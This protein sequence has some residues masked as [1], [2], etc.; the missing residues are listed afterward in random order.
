LKVLIVFFISL[1]FIGCSLTNQTNVTYEK[2]KP[3]KEVKNLPSNKVLKVLN[4]PINGVIKGNVVNI[5]YIDNAWIYYV[6]GTD[7][8]NKK[9]SY[10]EFSHTKK[11][12]N[13]GDLVYVVIKDGKLKEW[14]MVKR[15]SLNKNKVKIKNNVLKKYKRT[16][17]R[18][19]LSVPISESIDLD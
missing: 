17:K 7:L 12:V 18:Q 9:L 5:K 14:F 11:V 19:L 2:Y 13:K 10:A 1:L 6:K 4:K 8:N 15:K 16:K 3:R